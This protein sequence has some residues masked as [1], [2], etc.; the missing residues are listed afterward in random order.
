LYCVENA[1]CER[2]QKALHDRIAAL[3]TE[4]DDIVAKQEALKKTL[5]ARFGDSINLES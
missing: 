5:Y 4:E 1:D 3:K 2:T